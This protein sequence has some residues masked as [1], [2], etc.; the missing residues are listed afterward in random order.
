[1]EPRADHQLPNWWSQAW[2]IARKDISIE[3][4]TGEIVVT[5]G[6]FAVLVTVIASLTLWSGPTTKNDVAAAVIWLS[7]AFAA[8][9]ALSRTWHREREESVLDAL[10]V[11]PASA[12]AIY[13]GKVIGVTLFL[14]T[15]ELLVI[16]TC[17]LFFS[18]D[19]LD[20]APSLVLLCA[21]ATP[22]VAASGCLFGVMTVRTR[23]RDLVLSIVLFPLLSPTLLAATVATRELFDGAP[24]SEL[25]DF[26]RIIVL[27][28]IVFIVGGLSLFGTL[29]EQ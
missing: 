12:S 10:L 15:I 23:A 20:Y 2:L 22:G 8:I 26:L 4:R 16:P 6:F 14:F 28:D 7:T 24:I 3:A 17:T 9:L 29:A 27:F 21:L 5:G 18:L 25:G 11:S 19:I 1:M 13:F